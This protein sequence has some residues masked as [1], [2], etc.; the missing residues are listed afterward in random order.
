MV[1]NLGVSGLDSAG[2]LAQLD[3]PTARSAVAGANIDLITVGANDFADDHDG[4]TDGDCPAGADDPCVRDELTRLRGN[5]A[6]ILQQIDRLRRGRPTAVLVTGYWNVYEDGAVARSSYSAA[7]RA[8]TLRLTSLV[9]DVIRDV[10]TAAR[11]TYVDLSQSFRRAAGARDSTDLLTPDGDHPDRVG[12][13]LIAQRLVAAG[14]P[15]LV[16][17]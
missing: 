8:A 7:G 3:D 1:D 10:T 2:L 14:L 12:H 5:L 15:G 9:N 13:A 11:D 6:A 16:D 17:G 4:V